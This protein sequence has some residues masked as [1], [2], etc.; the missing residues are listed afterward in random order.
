M[1][2]NK[3]EKLL[4]TKSF[5]YTEPNGLLEFAIDNNLYKNNP[6]NRTFSLFHGMYWDIFE[7]IK[8]CVKSNTVYHS[9]AVVIE[10]VRKEYKALRDK[11]LSSI[12][13][14]SRDITAKCEEASKLISSYSFN[15]TML[16][17]DST[18]EIKTLNRNYK[19]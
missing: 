7:N 19:Y 9:E 3:I 12:T 13:D 14:F 17:L 6:Y 18:I 4:T 8:S 10:A 16:F 11:L 5:N 2:T 1:N 15:N